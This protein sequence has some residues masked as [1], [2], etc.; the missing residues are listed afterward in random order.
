MIDT[1]C[2]LNFPQ[3]KGD[4]DNLLERAA[5][6]GVT[7]MIT[8]GIDVPSSRKC[9]QIARKH[10]QVSASVGIHPNSTESVTEAQWTDLASLACRNEVVAIGET[11]LDYY[12]NSSLRRVQEAAFRRQIDISL[13]K[14]L[15]LVVH[16][17]EAYDDCYEIMSGLKRPIKGVMHCFSG[18]ARDAA[19]FSELGLYLS[20]A[21][22]ITFPGAKELRTIAGGV[23]PEI[24]LLETD[25][26]FLAPQPRRGKRNEPA[27]VRYNALALA[28]IFGLTLT[29]ID[30][31]TTLNADILFGLEPLPE[32]AKLAY[33]IR[34]SLYINLTSKCSN[35]CGFC[36]KNDT[37][38][39]KGHYLALDSKPAVD[40]IMSEID[41]HSGYREIVFCGLGEPTYRL[42]EIKDISARIRQHGVR[43]R[44]NTNGH[45]DL[46]NGREI[47]P[48]LEGLVDAVSISLNQPDAASYHRVCRPRFGE[49]T[50]NAIINF[51]KSA[52]L[53]IPEVSITVLDMPGVDIEACKKIAMQLGVGF[54]LRD[55]N[56]VG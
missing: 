44:I 50:F 35:E 40:E 52:A 30:R 11:G 3:F 45:G 54:R 15:P 42:D 56:V 38:Y 18:T 10:K 20:F 37:P 27:F 49:N 4:I 41:S 33:L 5:N 29:D 39:V 46:I 32:K 17:R 48:E 23:R 2:H 51:I 36:V 14:D 28:E 6:A 26:P 13:E 1:H 47:C 12:R 19:R 22:P 53:N 43:V 34:D 21:G 8:I 55:Y 24:V 31:I 16:C 9:I 25:S 7:K